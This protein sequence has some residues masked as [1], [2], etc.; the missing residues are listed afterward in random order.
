M[1]WEQSLI[2]SA[3]KE[4]NDIS[5]LH[6]GYKLGSPEEPKQKGANAKSHMS[7]I[8]PNSL[9]TSISQL[10]PGNSKKPTNAENDWSKL[11]LQGVFNSEIL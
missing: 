2:S 7:L 4:W 1:I 11:Q 6:P 3:K 9:S 5:K 10:F 8:L